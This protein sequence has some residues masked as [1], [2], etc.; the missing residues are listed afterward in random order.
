MRLA[1]LGASLPCARRGAPDPSPDRDDSRTAPPPRE[2]AGTGPP[3]SRHRRPSAAPSAPRPADGATRPDRSTRA[4]PAAP[5]RAAPPSPASPPPPTSAP[6]SPA[7]P[8]RPARSPAP[9]PSRPHPTRPR[10]LSPDTPTTPEVVANDSR[11][12]A[13][14]APARARHPLHITTRRTPPHV[15]Q[16]APTPPCTPSPRAKLLRQAGAVVARPAIG[17]EP[18]GRVAHLDQ[19][20]RQPRHDPPPEHRTMRLE[21]GSSRQTLEAYHHSTERTFDRAR[22]EPDRVGRHP[23]VRTPPGP[24]PRPDQRRDALLRAARQHARDRV[25]LRLRDRQLPLRLHRDLPGHEAAAVRPLR[26]QPGGGVAV[27]LAAS[28]WDRRPRA[29]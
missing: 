18:S 6:P 12:C 21:G 24:A 15:T 3:P 20:L 4:R 17:L 29:G 23:V 8:P 5:P 14:V 19:Q 13:G 2:A 22:P 9:A 28:W 11:A 16:R 1:G 27:A 10:S 26:R 25:V 7:P